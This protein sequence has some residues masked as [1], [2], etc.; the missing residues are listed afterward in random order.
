MANKELVIGGIFLQGLIAVAERDGISF[1]EAAQK[2]ID[3]CKATHG[4]ENIPYI[5]GALKALTSQG[6]SDKH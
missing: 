6:K 5:E 2:A 4:E 1:Q 3:E